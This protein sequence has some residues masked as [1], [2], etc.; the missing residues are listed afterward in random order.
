MLP[1]VK[2][3]PMPP[4]ISGRAMQSKGRS[5]VRYREMSMGVPGRPRVMKVMVGAGGHPIQ[6]QFACVVLA[7]ERIREW[8]V[9][10]GKEIEGC[11][12][13]RLNTIF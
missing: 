1:A 4:M 12:L 11:F 6:Q 9:V 5:Q 8:Q 7:V 13:D 10:S 3:E 2:Y